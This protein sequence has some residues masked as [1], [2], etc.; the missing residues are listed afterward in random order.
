[1]IN[2]RQFYLIG[3]ILMFISVLGQIYNQ[4]LVWNIVTIGAKVSSIAGGIL[5]SLLLTVFFLGLWYK[6]P[7]MPD[8]VVNN[9]ELDKLL[10]DISEGDTKEEVVA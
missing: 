2:I 10:K 8:A 7:K 4:Y 1:M 9:A 6:T 3:G 5:F